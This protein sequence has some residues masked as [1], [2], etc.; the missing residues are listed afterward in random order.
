VPPSYSSGADGVPGWMSTKKLPSRNSRG[1]I[2]SVA[3]V[4][5]GSALSVAETLKLNI[6]VAEGAPLID[7]VAALRLRP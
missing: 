2:L 7:P 6:P 4:C 5:S 1:R 3:S